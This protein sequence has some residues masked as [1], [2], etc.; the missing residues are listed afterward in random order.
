TNNDG[1]NNVFALGLYHH[2]IHT[3]G[4]FDAVNFGTTPSPNWGRYLETGAPWIAQQPASQ[5]IQCHQNATFHVTVAS[6]YTGVTYTWAK[7]AMSMV[8][9]PTAHGSTIA[10]ASTDTLTITNANAGDAG[11]YTCAVANSC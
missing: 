9:G 6:G 8:D 10:G 3:S 4:D 11:N 2:E 1:N 5:N 7:N